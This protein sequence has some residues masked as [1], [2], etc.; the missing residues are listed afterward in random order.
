M[1]AKSPGIKLKSHLD[2]GLLLFPVLDGTL[3]FTHDWHSRQ[4]HDEAGGGGPQPK[5]Q[6][7]GNL[8]MLLLFNGDPN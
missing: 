2:L 3:F 5:G 8:N 4:T 1:S 6:P 7:G